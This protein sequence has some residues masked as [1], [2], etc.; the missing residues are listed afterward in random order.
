MVKLKYII[1]VIG[2]I[3]AMTFST[4][5]IKVFAETSGYSDVLA[6]L[7]KDEAFVASEYVENST[8]YS[9]Q[10]IQIA[11]SEDDEL[12]V[13]VYQ[14]S[15]KTKDLRASS[16]NIARE[17]DNSAGL[18]FSNYS[19]EYI[20]S[21]GV[22]Y[23]YKVKDLELRVDA[24]RYYNISNIYRPW[25]ETDEPPE[26]GNTT[27]GVGFAVGQF[28]TVCTIGDT[29]SYSMIGTDVVTI[30]N[31]YDGYLRYENGFYLFQN[32]CDS[33]YVAFSTD[34]DMDR[35]FEVDLEY[36]LT[37]Y[38]YHM[39][40]YPSGFGV[41]VS[42]GTTSDEPVFVK[43][44]VTYLEEGE[45]SPNGWAG[46]K[47]T[48]DRIR[49]V[50]DFIA[51]DMNDF[52]ED[53]LKRLEDK[54]WVVC[55]AETEYTF[56][57]SSTATSSTYYENYTRVSELT[58]LRL[59]FEVD[60]KTYNLGVVDNKTSEGLDQEPDS[61]TTLGGVK[62][63]WEMFISGLVWFLFALVGLIV[64]IAAIILLVMLLPIVLPLFLNLIIAAGKFLAKVITLPFRAIASLINKNRGD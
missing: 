4:V 16:I 19:L 2:L 21:N 9:L 32:T 59:K 31:R 45:Y 3:I 24:V 6:D 42:E 60:G 51:D 22:F 13:Y 38:H 26:G 58:I 54:Q 28:W 12:F 48:W 23:K 34:R 53:A 7:Q 29:V 46:K 56:G 39:N 61:E 36:Y 17:M 40:S 25:I 27:E 47:Y 49:T 20:N 50:D 14:P 15:G 1:A 57:G 63:M 8:D 18:G 62:D 11:E 41:E 5:P 44:T 37:D 10:V 33:H 64:I 30:T 55:F 52:T 35:L 43:Q